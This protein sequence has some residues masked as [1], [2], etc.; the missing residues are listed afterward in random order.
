MPILRTPVIDWRAPSGSD[1][2]RLSRKR[3]VPSSFEI[4]HDGLQEG[5][6]PAGVA[7][8]PR[9][10]FLFPA[11]EGKIGRKH[12]A[13]FLASLSSSKIVRP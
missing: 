5:G 9:A 8:M 3:L 1:C 7:M 6:R 13:A 2:R 11:N 12:E 4:S 10:G